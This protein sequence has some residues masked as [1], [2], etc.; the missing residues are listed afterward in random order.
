MLARLSFLMLTIFA[1]ALTSIS[2]STAADL[3]VLFLGDDGNHKPR[4]RYDQ[5]APILATQ[6][7]KLVYTDNVEDL[8]ALSKDQYSALMVYA[9][10]DAISPDQA[11]GLLNYVKTGGGF[12]PLHCA[13]FCFRNN[14]EVVG[15]IGAQFQRHGTGVFRTVSTGTDHPILQGM[16]DIESWDETYVHSKHNETD[17]TVLQFRVDSDGR[18]PWT[19]VKT[20]GDGR[21]FY[22]AWGHDDRTWS[23]AGFIELVERGIRWACKQELST[24]MHTPYLRQHLLLWLHFRYLY[25]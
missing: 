8:T 3:Q 5:L 14:D 16:S 12:V 13:S 9:N 23:N 10:I 25:H 1:L 20:F 22:T 17:R 11:K 18:E 2:L 24:V 6:E 4:A 7:I 19:W 15:L 21:V